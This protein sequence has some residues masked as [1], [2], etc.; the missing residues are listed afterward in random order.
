M[1]ICWLT[2]VS[3]ETQIGTEKVRQAVV[4]IKGMDGSTL[5]TG[6][7]AKPAGL[8]LTSYA[9]VRNNNKVVVQLMDKK[10]LAGEILGFDKKRNLALV[11]I[12]S[13]GLPFLKLGDSG[14]VRIFDKVMALGLQ[15]SLEG[16]VI[17]V[18]KVEKLRWLKSTD[19]N[20]VNPFDLTI[21]FR[22]DLEVF[23]LYKGSPLLNT[24]GEV[25]GINMVSNGDGKNF[26]YSMAI[27]EA[28][29]SFPEELR[30]IEET[31]IE[32][33]KGKFECGIRGIQFAMYVPSYYIPTKKWPLI[34]AFHP[35]GDG[36]EIRDFWADE[37]ENNGF[38]IACGYTYQGE[39]WYTEDDYKIFEMMKQIF[40]IYNIDKQRIYLTGLSGGAVFAYYLGINYSE[41]FSAIAAVTSGSI[42]CI[43]NELDYSR[44]SRRHIP[45]LIVH[46]TDD[47]VVP[48]CSI[49]RDRDKLRSYGYKVSYQEIKGMG[50]EH[51][52]YKS[53]I[54]KKIIDFFNKHRK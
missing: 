18:E 8:I 16:R 22:T 15:N 5:G 20:K 28:F 54:Y 43:E 37:A 46:G 51:Q 14:T 27:N 19:K 35:A 42:Y 31:K 50:H 30:E 45:I 24:K 3:A 7:L 29:E 40:K 33:K 11:K 4:L 13:S 36:R 23:N 48:L 44:S 52:P 10:E 12:E 17:D 34:L 32:I 6:F 39:D 9:V 26:I 53:E 1:Q 38:I 47:T 21:M 49:E 2:C 25:I 41:F